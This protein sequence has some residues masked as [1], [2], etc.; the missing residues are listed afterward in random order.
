VG[1]AACAYFDP[2][3][4]EDFARAINDILARGGPALRAQC[5]AQAAGF[6]WRA[7]LAAILERV[8]AMQ[9]LSGAA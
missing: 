4:A 8:L 5:Q 6:T 9:V 3:S 1:G 2:L 7:A